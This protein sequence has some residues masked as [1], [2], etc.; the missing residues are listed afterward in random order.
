MY[1]TIPRAGK[2][3]LYNINTIARGVYVCTHDTFCLYIYLYIFFLKLQF[4]IKINIY[5]YVY[6]YII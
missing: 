3:Y 2:T 4:K 5:I 1:Y 6:V